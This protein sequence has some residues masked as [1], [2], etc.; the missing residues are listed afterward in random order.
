MPV[1]KTQQA[2]ANLQLSVQPTYR[3]NSECAQNFTTGVIIIIIYVKN[4]NG[5]GN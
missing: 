1:K 4:G 3:V 2:L 5:N